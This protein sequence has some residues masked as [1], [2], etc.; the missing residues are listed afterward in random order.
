[1]GVLVAACTVVPALG[2]EGVRPIVRLALRGMLVVT[3]VTLGVGLL[4]L[5]IA[6]VVFDETN[7]PAVMR[8]G[9]VMGDPVA[10]W[11]A[12]TMHD[13]S[14]LGGAVGGIVG[15]VATVRAARLSA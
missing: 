12:G 7:V 2:A 4:A 1:M 13:F 5:G 9:N 14:Y 11:R 15:C 10:F 6:F 8:Y 3:A